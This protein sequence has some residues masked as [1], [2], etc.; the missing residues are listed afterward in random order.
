MPEEE[1]SL[2]PEA[3]SAPLSASP[4]SAPTAPE[5]RPPEPSAEPPL[6]EPE[7][8]ITPTPPAPHEPALSPETGSA[9]PAELTIQHTESPSPAPAS[10]T[11]PRTQST[12][13][14]ERTI[15]YSIPITIYGRGIN[16]RKK[17]LETR[18]HKRDAR[19]EKIRAH[20]DAHASIDNDMI[21]KL[22]RVSDATAT[23]YARTLVAEGK[24]FARGR[25][26]SVIYTAQP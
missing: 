11:N 6:I 7:E 25:G 8:V 4:D 13:V 15:P 20:V 9:P 3:A 17:S 26:R 12:R 2:P 18:K 16:G 1:I 19:L 21:V 5:E 24:L 23:R 14:V 22:L 10:E